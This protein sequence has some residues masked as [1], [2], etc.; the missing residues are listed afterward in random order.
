M[1]PI[2]NY[3]KDV[4]EFELLMLSDT[5]SVRPVQDRDGLFQVRSDGTF[6]S[7]VAVG[8]F[9]VFGIVSICFGGMI[10]Y[11][12]LY[13]QL[14]VLIAMEFLPLLLSL[15]TNYVFFTD[16]VELQ[17]GDYPLQ[18]KKPIR[19]RRVPRNR[20]CGAKGPENGMTLLELDSVRSKNKLPLWL[21]QLLHPFRTM[22]LFVPK[23]ESKK[24]HAMLKAYAAGA[25]PW[26]ST[27]D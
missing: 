19:Y 12:P 17:L 10:P 1:D 2:P 3:D 24:V 25:S 6:F 21:L 16:R 9:F 26:F 22:I 4:T 8:I 13:V 18:T 15:G 20:I 23:K 7:A 5:I 27:E 11:V 14:P